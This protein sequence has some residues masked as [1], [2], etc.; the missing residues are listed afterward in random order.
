MDGI[1]DLETE[2]GLLHGQLYWREFFYLIAH[3]TPN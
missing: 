3:A 1:I 2:A